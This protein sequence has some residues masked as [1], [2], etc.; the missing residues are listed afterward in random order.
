MSN[1]IQNDLISSLHSVLKTQLVLSLKNKKISIMADETSDCCHHEQISV[2]VRFYDESL[3]KP[4][5]Y[6][7][8]MQRLTA[9]DAQSIF[10]SLDGIV[11]NQL[12]LSW[13]DIIVVCFD[14]VSTMAGNINGVQAKCKEKNSKIFY[15]HCHAHCLN[16]VL[17]DSIGRSNCIVFDFLLVLYNFYMHL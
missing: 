1:L 4:V 13:L 9:V 17:I 15:V 14:G 11:V 7:V 12:G 3:N 16:L 8:C 2:I 6:F 10:N 5:E